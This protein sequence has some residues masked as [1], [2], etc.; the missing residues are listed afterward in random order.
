VTLPP[1]NTYKTNTIRNNAL[2]HYSGSRKDLAGSK[3]AA[4]SQGGRK[5]YTAAKR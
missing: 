2:N 4:K 5:D 1:K 3:L